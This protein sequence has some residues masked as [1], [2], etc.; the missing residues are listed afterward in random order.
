MSQNESDDPVVHFGLDQR[1]FAILPRAQQQWKR[2]EDVV[3]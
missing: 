3:L 1:P 2:E